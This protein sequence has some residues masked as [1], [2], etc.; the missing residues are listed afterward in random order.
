MIIIGTAHFETVHAANRYYGKRE[1]QRKI[2]EGEIYIGKPEL[3][4]GEKLL[5]DKK[6]RRYKIEAENEK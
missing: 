1:A 2:N 4:Q 3:K 5:I 6:E